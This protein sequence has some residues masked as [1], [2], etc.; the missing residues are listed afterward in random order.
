L[1]ATCKGR[2]AQKLALEGPA[3]WRPHIGRTAA[4]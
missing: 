4:I 1:S 2:L 3:H